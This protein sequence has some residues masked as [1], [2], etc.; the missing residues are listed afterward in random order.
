ML[1]TY[2][3]FGMGSYTT[4]SGEVVHSEFT[5]FLNGDPTVGYFIDEF[6]LVMMFCVLAIALAI[7]KY[8]LLFHI[9]LCDQT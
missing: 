7:Y 4:A 1:N 2:I 3:Y 5:R 9:F 8:A 6:Y